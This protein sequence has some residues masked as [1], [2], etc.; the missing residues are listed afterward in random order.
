MHRTYIVRI[1]KAASLRHLSVYFFSSFTFEV[2]ATFLSKN[3]GIYGFYSPAGW[4]VKNRADST[5]QKHLGHSFI[6]PRYFE[7]LITKNMVQTLMAGDQAKV[8]I[9]S[10]VNCSEEYKGGLR[11]YQ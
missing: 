8:R 10:N 2:E 4:S 11:S 3:Y 6:P 1:Q 5:P 9:Y 7:H